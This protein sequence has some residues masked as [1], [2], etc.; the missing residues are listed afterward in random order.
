VSTQNI[1]DAPH[2]VYRVLDSY[3]LL[4]YIGCSHNVE[5]RLVQHQYGPWHRY[6]ETVGIWGPYPKAEA[7]RMESEAIESEASY[8]NSTIGDMARA[9]RNRFTALRMARATARP[10]SEGYRISVDRLQQSLSDSGR[11]P[12]LTVEDR[13]ARYLAAR[14]DAELARLESVA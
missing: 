4:L 9:R 11:C 10:G 12:R 14:E 7:R 1:E 13:L 3:G 5:K 8:F 2:Y 6:A